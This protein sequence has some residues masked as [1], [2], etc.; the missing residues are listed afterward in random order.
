MDF[1]QVL[2]YPTAE[3]ISMESCMMIS[4]YS[5]NHMNQPMSQSELEDLA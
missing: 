5:G 3:L 4:I 1:A 2:I